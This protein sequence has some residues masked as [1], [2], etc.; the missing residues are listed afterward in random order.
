VAVTARRSAPL[1]TLTDLGM[2]CAHGIAV[3]ATR[4]L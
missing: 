3:R 1:A 2:R 4:V